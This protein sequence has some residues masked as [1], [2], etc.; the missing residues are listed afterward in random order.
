VSG[1]HQN[2]D[3]LI[4][5][6]A[7]T[8]LVNRFPD[9]A[10]HEAIVEWFP[11]LDVDGFELGI[12]RVWDL[13]RVEHDLGSAGLRFATAHA[14]KRIGAE[15]LDDAE[16][17]LA[18]LQASCRLA[19]AFGAQLVVL[20]LWELPV[21]DRRLDEN[22]ALLPA[23]LDVAEAAG[24]TLAVETIPCSVGSPLENVRRALDRDDRCRVTLDTEFLAHHGQLAAALEDDS[25]WERVV[26]V[27]VKD[28]AGSLRDREGTRKYLIPGEGAIDFEEVFAT[29][30]HR[31][32]DGALTLEVSAVTAEGLVD[33]DRFRQAE[34]WL[35]SRP[36]LLPV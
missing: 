20:H 13:A 3:D 7:S 31:A 28:Y 17:A 11:A 24:V 21:G 1:T 5:G 12:G 22:L 36:W 19:A 16:A 15:L 27:H 10:P 8:G 4:R 18:Q 25:L 35:T 32:Y 6:L 34:A 23:C 30:R 26:H 33:E 14:D 9:A 2:R 29:L